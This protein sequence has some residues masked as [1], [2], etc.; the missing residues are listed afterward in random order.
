MKLYCSI[1]S[2]SGI[3]AVTVTQGHDS[4][5]SS[6]IIEATTPSVQ[7]GD[8]I[9][10]DLGYTTNHQKV[11]SGYVKSIERRVP[12]NTYI[13]TAY[14]V[15]IRAIDY[16]IVADDPLNPLSYQNISAE[17]L[18]ADLFSKAGL[19]SFTYDTTYFVFG[20]NESFD[21]NLVSPLDYSNTIA[22]L[23]TWHLWADENGTIHFEN[24]KPYVMTGDTSQPGDTVDERA[25]STS[26]TLNDD[27]TG[28]L[29]AESEKDLRNKVV[30]YGNNGVSAVAQATSPYEPSGFYKATV[31]VAPN[32]IDDVATAQKTADY[33]LNL[34]NRLTYSISATVAGDPSLRARQIINVNSTKLGITN[35]HYYVF[36]CTHNFSKSGYINELE[37]RK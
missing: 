31:L 9:E 3:A 7:I 22:S 26:Y 24:R 15:M 30:V 23:I 21:I 25:I 1:T 2:I 33:N 36:G 19:T 6:A 5:T 10:V 35:T 14:D 8:Y 34:L 16:F 29:Y 28:L 32:V 11:F 17:D 12:T 13:V 27:A 37:L 4:D 18:V 20:I